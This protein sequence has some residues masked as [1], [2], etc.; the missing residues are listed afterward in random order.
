MSGIVAVIPIRSFSDGKS[1]LAG[2]LDG[3]SR[4]GLV[5]ALF[6]HVLSA[7]QRSDAVSRVIVVSPDPAVL[8]AAVALDPS[9]A[10]VVQPLDRPGLN[11]A[12]DLGRE[13]AIGLRASGMLVLFG[14]LPVLEPDDVR[15]LVRRDAPLII[16]TD[17]H[18]SGTNALMLRLGSVAARDFRF[19]YGP[20]SRYV[21]L[22][23]AERHGLD[24]VTAISAGTA[25]DL[26]TLEDIELLQAHGRSLPEW[27]RIADPEAQEKSA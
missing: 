10:T 9:V 22:E 15:S 5:R 2:F 26:D 23:E 20:N 21:H 25:I 7:V 14:D 11:A 17:R 27:L 19:A 16:A 24:A 4:A 8:A 18:G 13:T 12:V 1:R 6:E 3:E